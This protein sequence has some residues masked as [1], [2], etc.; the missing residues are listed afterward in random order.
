M[1]NSLSS[2]Y[3]TLI[4]RLG[5]VGQNL[6]TGPVRAMT[7]A[8]SELNS[9]IN[10]IKTGTAS[11]SVLKGVLGGTDSAVQNFIEARTAVEQYSEALS[12][13]SK[14]ET[15]LSSLEASGAYDAQKLETAKTALA[16]YR[17]EI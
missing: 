8:Y 4:S 15:Q 16:S 10:S 5:R 7:Q 14:L 3:N 2:S 13:L 1:V 9:V 6:T 17:T 11:N 12:Q